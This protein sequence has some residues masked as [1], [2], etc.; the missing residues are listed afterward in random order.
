MQYL[1]SKGKGKGEA[2]NSD[3]SAY[4]DKLEKQI[5][6]NT[7]SDEKEAIEKELKELLELQ[8]YYF[9]LHKPLN[10]METKL[11]LSRL[12]YDYVTKKIKPLEEEIKIITEKYLALQQKLVNIN[13][14]KPNVLIL[15]LTNKEE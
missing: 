8:K 12:P 1:Y 15:T 14:S 11:L 5:I 9:D 3:N 2:N 13:Y 4:F 10:E 6:E 7:K